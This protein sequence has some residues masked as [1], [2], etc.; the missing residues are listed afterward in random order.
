MNLYINKY[1][2]LVISPSRPI[3]PRGIHH[4]VGIITVCMCVRAWTHART[5]TEAHMHTYTL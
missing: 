4:Y 2:Q 5:H 1:L 3:I